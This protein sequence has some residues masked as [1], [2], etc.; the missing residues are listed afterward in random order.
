MG[1]FIREE[2]VKAKRILQRA[3]LSVTYAADLYTGEMPVITGE[4]VYEID[5]LHIC[6]ACIQD[7]IKRA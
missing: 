2:P 5:G 1:Y 4:D 7:Y 3:I 6:G